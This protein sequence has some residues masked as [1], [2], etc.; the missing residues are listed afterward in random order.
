MAYVRVFSSCLTGLLLAVGIAGAAPLQDLGDSTFDPNTG[1]VWLDLTATADLSYDDVTRLL[2]GSSPYA[3]YRYASIAEVQTLFSDA[4]ITSTSGPW[5]NA[6]ALSGLLGQTVFPGP[7][8]FGSIGLTGDLD[9]RNPS[10]VYYMM[11]L[12]DRAGTF[13]GVGGTVFTFFVRPEFAGS[14]L[15][16]DARGPLLFD[17][18]ALLDAAPAPD[19]AF[20]DT[21]PLPPAVSLFASGLGLLGLLGWRRRRNVSSQCQLA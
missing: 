20:L 10:L 2:S 15:V 1:L 9:P 5:E 14:F 19:A 3:G 7:G 13:A 17:R 11:L 8:S 21:V 12:G 18:V 16:R 6:A 4:G